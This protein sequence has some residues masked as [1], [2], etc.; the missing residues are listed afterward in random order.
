VLLYIALQR[1]LCRESSPT[2]GID[3][4]VDAET[5]Q[6]DRRSRCSRGG[7]G[8]LREGLIAAVEDVG[9]ILARHAPPAADD[10]DEL[11]N[12]VVIA[13]GAQLPLAAYLPAPSTA[14]GIMPYLPG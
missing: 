6:G 10:I 1:A 8:A 13:V 12:K 14:P 3:G 5:W 7:A 11:P 4:K 9:S 2:A